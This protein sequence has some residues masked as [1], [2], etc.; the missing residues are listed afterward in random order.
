MIILRVLLVVLGLVL[1]GACIWAFQ[2]GHFLNEFGEI[3]AMPWGKVS[4]IDLYLGFFVFAVLF[5]V[6]EPIWLAIVLTL[7]MMTLG[8]WVPAFWLALRLP[9]L[10]RKLRSPG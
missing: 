4:L 7:L 9:K 3:S 2:A 1:I 8:N 5:F 6:I 10:F